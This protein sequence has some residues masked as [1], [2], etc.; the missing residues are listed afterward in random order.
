MSANSAFMVQRIYAAVRCALDGQCRVIKTHSNF[1]VVNRH[2]NPFLR[3]IENPQGPIF[4]RFTTTARGE[5]PPSDPAKPARR[6]K[7]ANSMT[8]FSSHNQSIATK[9]D[10]FPRAVQAASR[11]TFMPAGSSRKPGRSVDGGVIP[12]SA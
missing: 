12:D 2:H 9:P 1:Q 10:A 8:F 3:T 5:A 7:S 11:L 4:R 6:A